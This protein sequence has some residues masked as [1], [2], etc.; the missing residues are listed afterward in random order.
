MPQA[1]PLPIGDARLSGLFEAMSEGLVIHATDGRITEANQAAE[2]ILGLSRDE[3]L[4]RTSTDPRWRTVHEDGSPYVGTEHPAM[5][6]LRTGK[7]LREQVMGVHDPRRG[8]RWISVNASP[9]FRP[10]K[11]ALEGVVATFADITQRKRLD[12]QLAATAVELRDLYDL[13]PCGYYSLDAKGAFVKINATA[14]SWLGCTQEDIIGK[15]T[16]L[17]FFTAE[18]QKQFKQNFPEFIR[19]GHVEGL[20]FDLVPAQGPTR[21]VSVSATAMMGPDGTFLAS[22]SVWH[23]ITELHRARSRLLALAC[24]QDAMLNTDLI[25]IAKMRQ[26]HIV[27]TNR[28]MSSMLGYSAAEF[29]GQSTRMLYGNENAYIEAGIKG[30]GGQPGKMVRVQLEMCR[31]DSATIWVD[32]SSVL[33]SESSGE[34]LVLLMDITSLKQAEASRLEA[35][36]LEAD[37]RRRQIELEKETKLRTHIEKHADE[38]NKLLHERNEMLDV[39]AHEVRQ[40]LNNASA[41]LQ[42]AATAVS[43]LGE[44]NVSTD[45]LHAQAVMTQVM[46]SI[47]NTLAVASLLA[48]PDPLHRED[49]DL[50]TLLA[51]VIAEVPDTQRHRVQIERA[52]G[53]RTASMDMS[54][55]HL[56]LRNLLLNAMQNS[57]DA[58]P[59]TIRI[60]DSDQPL[61]LL[62]DV[63]NR[64]SGI[65]A[66]MVPHLF[67]RGKQPVTWPG[68][69]A[70]SLGLGLYI[71]RRVMELHNGS[72]ELTHNS[73]SGVTM[74]LVL[75]QSGNR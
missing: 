59:V 44:Q 24:E 4:G 52:T 22:R 58:S 5:V 54:L 69:R 67:E 31:K 55:M 15:K 38:L 19:R 9:I 13:A 71:V 36:R 14:L 29:L 8:L 27:W 16:P 32:V 50:D 68:K 75:D 3:I 53:T 37:A 34:F 1:F 12:Q 7:A 21:R 43:G 48:R 64:G 42:S 23:D 60:S 74:R 47:D 73:A 40:P 28:G 6:A 18:G 63:I 61:A 20:E 72:A 57:P 11:H 46:G 49:G 26:R 70:R 17:D 33:L 51:L 25:G 10:G 35:T 2:Q 66:D 30:A 45:L 56:A 65:P 41:A 39:L 62:I